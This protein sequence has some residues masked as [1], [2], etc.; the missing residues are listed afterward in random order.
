MAFHP[1]Q[2]MD[3][4]ESEAKPLS[5]VQSRSRAAGVSL[6]MGIADVAMLL[7]LIADTM[8]HMS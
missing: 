5:P 4:K 6:G 7:Q 1:D 3:R 8:G 2:D